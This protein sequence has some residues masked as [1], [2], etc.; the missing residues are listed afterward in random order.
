MKHIELSMSNNKLGTNVENL[1]YL[2]DS[3]KYLP[4]K[5]EYFNLNLESNELEDDSDNMKLFGE[6]IK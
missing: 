6:G 3:L 4:K 2:C 5:L 1:K